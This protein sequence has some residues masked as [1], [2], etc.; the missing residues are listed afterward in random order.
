[1]SIA[2]RYSAFAE[3]DAKAALQ[4]LL[5]SKDNPSA[6]SAVME[7]LGVILGNLLSSRIPN[8]LSCLLAS[9]AEDADFL[10]KGIYDRLK[11]D[12]PTKAAVFWNNHYSVA[13]GSVAPVV[14]KF[15]E[16]GYESSNVLIIAKSVISGSCVVRTNI[17]ELIE[18]IDPLKIFIVSPVMHSKSE[19]SL[20]DEFPDEISE[21]FEFLVLAIDQ[22]K[23]AT[24]E[25]LPG[26][27]GEIYSLLGLSDQPARTSY[28]PNLVKQLAAF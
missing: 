16:P 1:M 19:A 5:S 11:I 26:I 21:K 20:R 9:T 2:E 6:Y 8:D 25:V 3:D 17:L 4:S 14:H 10:S 22:D 18:H 13:G 15:L 23:S 7:S 28:M 27:G 12:H 24:G